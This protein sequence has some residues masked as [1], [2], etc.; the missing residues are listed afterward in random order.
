MISRA[1]KKSR[2]A[3]G[4]GQHAKRRA[5]RRAGPQRTS[6]SSKTPKPVRGERAKTV[7]ATDFDL[8]IAGGGLVGASLAAALAPLSLEV[9]VV[10]AVPF[11]APGQPSYDERVTALSVGSQRIFAR[12]GVWPVLAA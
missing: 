8:L 7:P 6:G 5:R 11:G 2:S 9:G 3:R 1:G 4:R 12:L 10:E